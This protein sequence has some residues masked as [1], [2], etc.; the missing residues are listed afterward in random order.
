MPSLLQSFSP[1]ARSGQSR[2]AKRAVKIRGLSCARGT[3]FFCL[4][5]FATQIAASEAIAANRLDTKR[6]VDMTNRYQVPMPSKDARVVLAYTGYGTRVRDR[7]DVSVYSPAFLLAK[8]QDGG[9][10]VLRGFRREVIPK[11]EPDRP[12][13]I[14]PFLAKE[15]DPEAAGY[16]PDFHCRS[17]FV[18]AVQLAARGDDANAQALWQ[19][20]A[21]TTCWTSE[22]LGP[23]TR[24][25]D[26]KAPEELRN[27][28]LFFAERVFDHLESELRQKEANRQ[29]V[30][31]R[32]QSL[33]AEMPELSNGNRK[34]IFDDLAA[35]LKARPPA[36][37]S[38][39]ARLLE[40]SRRYHERVLFD[41]FEWCGAVP[42]ADAPRARLSY[43]DSMPFRRC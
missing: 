12:R 39:E 9:V 41:P 42:P 11:T 32:M 40:W 36:P 34:T 28:A 35:T 16:E 30:Y 2:G 23:S 18:C 5:H 6:L 19:Q 3:A 13:L 7:I 8:Q 22:Y 37:G 20:V 14:R 33:L 10:V 17:A 26:R 31:K 25:A 15:I 27:P 4:V 24:Q 29:T 21:S 1:D 38:V 43:R